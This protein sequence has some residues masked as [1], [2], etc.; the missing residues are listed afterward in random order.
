MSLLPGVNQFRYA[1]INATKDGDNTVIAAVEGKKII[2]LGYTINLNAAGTVQFQDSAAEAP[3]VFA[4]YE[5]PDGGGA[6][7]GGGLECPAFEVTRS[8]GLEVSVAESVDAT[9]HLTYV[10][11]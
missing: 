6:S 4:G 3:A 2:V 10:L 7:Y 9:G 8:L 5:F 1:R 11:I